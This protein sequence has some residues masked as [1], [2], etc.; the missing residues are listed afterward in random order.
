MQGSKKRCQVESKI[1]Q[2]AC[3]LREKAEEGV[4]RSSGVQ[5]TSDDPLVGL[6]GAYPQS[7]YANLVNSNHPLS[8]FRFCKNSGPS[9]S[10]NHGTIQRCL[11]VLHSTYICI[12]IYICDDAD[13]MEI[14]QFVSCCAREV[15]G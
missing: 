4:N 6:S 7:R 15:L 13:W 2:E 9:A 1:D 3:G 10:V 5:R 14:F 11:I 12:Y 8:A